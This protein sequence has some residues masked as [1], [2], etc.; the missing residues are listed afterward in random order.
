VV[1]AAGEGNMFDAENNAETGIDAVDD[2]GIFDNKT[3]AKAEP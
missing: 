3:I 1:S 2:L